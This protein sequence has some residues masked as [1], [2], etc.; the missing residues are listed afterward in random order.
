MKKF[1]E[2]LQIKEVQQNPQQAQNINP[3]MGTQP[4]EAAKK[5]ATARAIKTARAGV[6]GKPAKVQIAALQQA[7][8]KLATDPNADDAA[9]GDI[10][11]AIK[12]IQNQNGIKPV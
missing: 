5:A 4:G 1:S 6:V 3:K 11:K 7:A 8:K 9:V 10:D 12:D 2:W